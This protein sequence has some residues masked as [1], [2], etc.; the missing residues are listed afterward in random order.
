MAEGSLKFCFRTC[1]PAC[2][3]LWPC[4]TLWLRESHLPSRVFGFNKSALPDSHGRCVSRNCA[5]VD[6]TAS[7]HPH[8]G[9]KFREATLA[10]LAS[11][12]ACRWRGDR[13]HSLGFADSSTP[14]SPSPSE[15]RSRADSLCDNAS[16]HGRRTPGSGRNSSI[17]RASTVR[18]SACSASATPEQ[19]AESE[20]L[21]WVRALG[22]FWSTGLPA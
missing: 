2:K 10:R 12:V 15:A 6:S 3:L 16:E 22:H 9:N 21:F 17:D 5:S 13:A 7:S 14:T 19:H 1:Q 8:W 20:S 11:S 18:G 4:S